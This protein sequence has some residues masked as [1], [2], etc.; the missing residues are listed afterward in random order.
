MPV[1]QVAIEL[2]REGGAEVA[3][4]FLPLTPPP[5]RATLYANDVH[6]RPVSARSG[7]SHFREIPLRAKTGDTDLPETGNAH[8]RRE[9]QAAG[10]GAISLNEEKH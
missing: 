4:V 3:V 10:G 7:R 1:F 2:S 6:S 5:T 8:P 9:P